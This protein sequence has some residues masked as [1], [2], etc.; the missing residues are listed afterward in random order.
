MQPS[1]VGRFHK[2]LGIPEGHGIPLYK[3]DE[4]TRSKSKSVKKMANARKFK[5]R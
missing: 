2:L 4:A 5:K 3:I 1:H